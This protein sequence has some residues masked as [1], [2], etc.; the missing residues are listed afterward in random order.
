ML[1]FQER[2]FWLSVITKNYFFS[3]PVNRKSWQTVYLYHLSSGGQPPA[4]QSFLESEVVKFSAE[5]ISSSLLNSEF[6]KAEE[7]ISLQKG[8]CLEKDSILDQIFQ[9]IKEIKLFINKV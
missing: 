5:E 1:C 7:K 4:H 2:F 8:R 3:H 6:L 9:K